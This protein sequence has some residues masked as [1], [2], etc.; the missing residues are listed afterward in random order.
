MLLRSARGRCLSVRPLGCAVLMVFAALGTARAATVDDPP[1]PYVEPE[2]TDLLAI[3]ND[4][5][6][7]NPSYAAARSAYQAAQEAIPLARGKLLPQLGVRAQIDRVNEDIEGNYYGVVD[8]SISEIYTRTLYGAQLTQAIYRPDLFLGL[9]KAELQQK[10]AFF[11]MD[12]AQDALLLGSAEAYFGVLAAQDAQIF[13]RAQ[14]LTLRQQLDYIRSRTDAGLATISD[15]KAAQAA[16]EL[17]VADAA[18]A[19]NTLTAAL[20][21]LGSLTGKN[22]K[23]LKRLPAEIAL[24]PPQP[25]DE[26]I[27]IERAR[28]QNPAVLAARASMEVARV[29]RRIAQRGRYPKIDVTGLAYKLDNGGGLTGDRIEEDMRIG[30]ALNLP[31]YSGGQISA[32]IRG[33]T[34]LEDKAEAE[35]EAATARAVRETRIAYLNTSAGLQRVLALQRAVEAAIEAEGSARAGYDSGTRT[36]ADVLD[37]IDKRYQAEANFA[38]ARYKFL[39][40]SLQLKQLS[41]NLLVSDLAQINR[42]LQVPA[43]AASNP[44]SP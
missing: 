8:I 19:D 36:N 30:A 35:A 24:T 4:A 34:A 33:A 3:C 10:Q 20:I 11:G 40:N 42:L 38:A 21:T 23:K 5:L 43:T 1:P 25:A 22:Y 26:N 13:A 18:A 28:T 12:A 41:G 29:D 16:H 17:A 9:S 2:F 44:A 37:A 7:S 14:L 15:L 6:L 39:V 31:L 27:W 32:A